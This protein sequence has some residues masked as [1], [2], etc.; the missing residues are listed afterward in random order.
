[1]ITQSGNYLLR[2]VILNGTIA[3]RKTGC[4]LYPCL[5]RLCWE[6]TLDLG[7][8]EVGDPPRRFWLYGREAHST[9]HRHSY[10]TQSPFPLITFR[11][12]GL[13]APMSRARMRTT[14]LVPYPLS[15]RRGQST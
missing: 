11:H 15:I 8:W 14:N 5:H 7:P 4:T 2:M 3:I 13:R 10:F 12:S 9:K 6:G 1:M